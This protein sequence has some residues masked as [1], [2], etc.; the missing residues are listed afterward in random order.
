MTLPRLDEMNLKTQD[1]VETLAADAELLSS[2]FR[3]QVQAPAWI[4]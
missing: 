3:T 4:P 2:M 1:A